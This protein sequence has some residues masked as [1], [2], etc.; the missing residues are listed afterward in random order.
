LPKIVYANQGIVE[1]LGALCSY[2]TDLCELSFEVPFY[3]KSAIQE[4]GLIDIEFKQVWPEFEASCGETW[5][6]RLIVDVEIIES[7]ISKL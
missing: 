6:Y 3:I 4:N 1:P 2:N 5:E 7:Y